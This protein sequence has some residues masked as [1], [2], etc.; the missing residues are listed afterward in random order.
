MHLKLFGNKDAQGRLGHGSLW[1]EKIHADTLSRHID[2]F[3]EVTTL[4]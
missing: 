3:S 2:H 4:S 1:L